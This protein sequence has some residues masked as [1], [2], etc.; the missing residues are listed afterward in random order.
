MYYNKKAK[1]DVSEHRMWH[2]KIPLKLTKLRNAFCA[3]QMDQW[4]CLYRYAP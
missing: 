4:T 3:L 2:Q 1:V